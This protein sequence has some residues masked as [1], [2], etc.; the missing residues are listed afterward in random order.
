MVTG[1]QACRTNLTEPCPQR[2]NEPRWL[3][4]ASGT[5]EW[6]SM[7][8]RI[9]HGF[10]DQ[11]R[12]DARV[13]TKKRSKSSNGEGEERR[14]QDHRLRAISGL[15]HFTTENG[16]KVCECIL[17]VCSRIL[18]PSKLVC[19]SEQ[20]LTDGQRM[21]LRILADTKSNWFWN[22]HS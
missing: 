1:R 22:T 9:G 17:C 15:A 14:R 4:P 19:S 8:A 20:N 18:K 11:H 10:E 21:I 3:N 12:G 2:V 7:P 5:R 16:N 6:P 13:A